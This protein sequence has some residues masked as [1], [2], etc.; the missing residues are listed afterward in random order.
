METL[1]S[2]RHVIARIRKPGS[3]RRAPVAMAIRAVATSGVLISALALVGAGAAEA[4]TIGHAGSRSHTSST[5]AP[6]A[7]S[8]AAGHGAKA[9]VTGTKHC[10]ATKPVV[11][12]RPW[13]YVISVTKGPW[14]FTANAVHGP[15]MFTASTGAAKG[16]WMFT[17]TANA[18][19]GP[20][21]FSSPASGTACTTGRG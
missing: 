7:Q 14:M 9:R 21:M 17:A 4:A 12:P 16:P 3:A 1:R 18:V 20:W 15:W 5:H 10:P 6:S 8:E 13:L 2:L 11:H 19:K